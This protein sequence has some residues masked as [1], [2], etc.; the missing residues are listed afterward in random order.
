[1][2]I[3]TNTKLTNNLNTILT[4]REGN[5]IPENAIQL[6]KTDSMSSE[7]FFENYP[8]EHLND[9]ALEIVNKILVTKN[10]NTNRKPDNYQLSVIKKHLLLNKNSK[11]TL[12]QVIEGA[13]IGDSKSN[14]PIEV[15]NLTADYITKPKNQARLLG[16]WDMEQRS[17]CVNMSN[18]SLEDLE[19]LIY[20]E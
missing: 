19:R 3:C 5:S 16:Y 17:T 13:R 1:M 8:Y 14:N 12:I 6:L 4:E 11:E 18:E 9:D 20:G 2:K 7:L 15:K 10:P